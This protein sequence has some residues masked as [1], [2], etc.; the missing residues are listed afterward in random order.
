VRMT[1]GATNCVEGLRIGIV[2][3]GDEMAPMR[4]VL[5]TSGGKI[6]FT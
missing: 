4:Y 3:D 2:G 6:S 5:L 1:L